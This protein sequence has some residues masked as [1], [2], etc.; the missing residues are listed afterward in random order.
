METSPANPFLKIIVMEV[1]FLPKKAIFLTF[2]LANGMGR[3][4]S[5]GLTIVENKP[6]L[7]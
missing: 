4:T 1:F 6:D 3:L 7:A 5:H 2:Q